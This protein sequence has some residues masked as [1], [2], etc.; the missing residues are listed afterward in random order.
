MRRFFEAPTVADQAMAI[1]E[2]WLEELVPADRDRMLADRGEN[3]QREQ[4]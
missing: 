4:P 3:A 2:Q 1:V